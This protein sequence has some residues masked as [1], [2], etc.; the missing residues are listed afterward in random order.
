MVKSDVDRA[1]LNVGAYWK[2]ARILLHF[3]EFELYEVTLAPGIGPSLQSDGYIHVLPASSRL[4]S[5]LLC[6][7]I[8]VFESFGDL[9]WELLIQTA[10]CLSRVAQAELSSGSFAPRENGP[11]PRE[12]QSMSKSTLNLG[13]LLPWLREGA[14][15]PWHGNPLLLVLPAGKRRLPF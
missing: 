5:I 1:N 13:D 10:P 4:E 2:R 9:L 12:S 6:T 15:Q 14:D 11:L 3:I 8:H 7:F